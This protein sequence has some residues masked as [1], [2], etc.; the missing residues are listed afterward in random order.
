LKYKNR[1]TSF[2]S[3]FLGLGNA[4]V[5]QLIHL[6]NDHY[7]DW[8]ETT[9][10]LSG[11]L[12]TIV[13]FGALFRPVEFTFHRKDKN[14]HHTMNDIRLPPSCMTSMEK[15]QRFI[16]EMD[17]QHA[18]RRGN[19]QVSISISNNERIPSTND[20]NDSI[21]IANESDLFDSYSADDITEIQNEN[22]PKIDIITFREKISNDM[23]FLNE[24]W[25]KIT[26]K[27]GE[28]GTNLKLFRMPNFRYLIS[29]KTK[30]RT[31]T[32]TIPNQ[33]INLS[34]RQVTNL[35]DQKPNGLLSQIPLE[36]NV[37]KKE[38]TT[39]TKTGECTKL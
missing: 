25:K 7:S 11:I 21:S 27:Q 1:S 15:L 34:S 3:Y 33:N 5:A 35:N 4:V 29:N 9:L 36:E 26:K 14:Y 28:T 39:T 38:T 6:L 31:N 17:K 12:F 30:E 23:T 16:S 13:L 22:R 37:N 10:F 18:S 8:R 24:R 32:L 2:I 20:D 19:Q